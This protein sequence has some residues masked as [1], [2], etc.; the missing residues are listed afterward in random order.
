MPS[1]LLVLQIVAQA[2]TEGDWLALADRFGVAAI[3]AVVASLALRK[4]YA[5]K[6]ELEQSVRTDVI[7][8]LV[9]ATEA[10]DRIAQIMERVERKL[11]ER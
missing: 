9:R 2:S 4:V 3:V 5:E 10:I 6:G 11:D 1:P 7:P 8:A